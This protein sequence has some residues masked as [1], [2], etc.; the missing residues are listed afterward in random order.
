[1]LQKAL[2][3]T[4]FAGRCS[5]V[6]GCEKDFLT[7]QLSRNGM[8]RSV[9]ACFGPSAKGGCRSGWMVSNFR[10]RACLHIT[11]RAA[12]GH[13]RQLPLPNSWESDPLEAMRDG[14]VKLYGDFQEG[15]QLEQAI[16]ELSAAMA[17]AQASR[18]TPSPTSGTSAPQPVPRA[19]QRQA[20]RSRLPRGA[21]AT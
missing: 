16:G 2:G 15:V 21:S 6:P 18:D 13:R 3:L 11:P 7:C 19:P 1:M 14:V 8:F 12:G 10:G 17:E 4:A 20:A 5:P 9:A